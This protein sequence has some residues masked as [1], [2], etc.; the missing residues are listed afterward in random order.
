MSYS[1]IPDKK[2]KIIKHKL[3]GDLDKSNMGKAWE[4]IA[5][6]KEFDELGYNVL[7]DYRDANFKFKIEETEFLDDF[8][9]G[10]KEIMNGKKGAVIVSVPLNTAISVLIT[11]KFKKVPNYEIKI[12]STEEAAIEWLSK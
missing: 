7:S 5:K 8:I 4:E 9:A 2:L 10:V 3:I 1:I 6:M 12:F 11:E